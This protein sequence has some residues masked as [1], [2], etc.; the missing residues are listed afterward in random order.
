[1][2]LVKENDEGQ[3]TLLVVA[4]TSCLIALLPIIGVVARSTLH[5][6]QLNNLADAAALAGAQELEFN[7]A[8]VCIEAQ[9]VLAARPDVQFQ[10]EVTSFGV[11]VSLAADQESDLLSLLKPRL[12]STAIAG[13]TTQ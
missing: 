1:M 6:Q 13:L 5:Q 11:Q 9:L 10:C 3:I 8:G 7:P 12:T 4:L 2:N